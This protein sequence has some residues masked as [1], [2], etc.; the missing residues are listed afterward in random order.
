M[1]RMLASP[2]WQHFWALVILLFTKFVAAVGSET[3]YPHIN[4]DLVRKCANN[5]LSVSRNVFCNEMAQ[6]LLS[7]V[8]EVVKANLSAGSAI[9]G[10]LPTTIWLIANNMEDIVSIARRDPAFGLTMMIVAGGASGLPRSGRSAEVDAGSWWMDLDLS[11]YSVN[12]V[13]VPGLLNVPGDSENK[14]NFI[15][16]EL[17]ILQMKTTE[18]HRLHDNRVRLHIY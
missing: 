4:Q 13:V 6:C 17:Q 1:N 15:R 11:Q 9:I 12:A 10:L 16:R 7:G 18:H 14:L 2:P 3:I 8:D 5:T